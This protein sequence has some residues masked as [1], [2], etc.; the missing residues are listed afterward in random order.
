MN[1]N[2]LHFH[3]AFKDNKLRASYMSY[4]KMSMKQTLQN[5]HKLL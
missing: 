1:M 3:L 2:Q 5:L 4:V